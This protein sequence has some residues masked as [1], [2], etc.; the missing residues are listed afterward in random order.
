MTLQQVLELSAKINPKKWQR[1]KRMK[2]FGIGLSRTGTKSLTEALNMLGINV[3]HYPNDETTLQ[4]LIAGNYEFSLLNSWD[5]ITDITVA[6][7]YAQLDKIY[8]DSKFILTV[9][10]GKKNLGSNQ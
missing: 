1:S 3:V 10:F 5:G 6:P 7:Y 2:V 4:E 8:P 9:R